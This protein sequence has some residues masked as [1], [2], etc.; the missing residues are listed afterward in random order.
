MRSR[1]DRRE[2]GVEIQR[3]PPKGTKPMARGPVGLLGVCAIPSSILTTQRTE[4]RRCGAKSLKEKVDTDQC[5]CPV[6]NPETAAQMAEDRPSWK[7]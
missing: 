4:Y 2:P 7:S 3:F 6:T 5:D 1:R